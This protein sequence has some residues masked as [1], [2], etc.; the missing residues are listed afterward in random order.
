MINLSAMLKEYR[1]CMPF[2]VEEVLLLPGH[3]LRKLSRPIAHC[4][5]SHGCLGAEPLLTSTGNDNAPGHSGY[6]VES[7]KFAQQP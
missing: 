4:K 1:I 6:W 2:T 3:I 5:I 7:E